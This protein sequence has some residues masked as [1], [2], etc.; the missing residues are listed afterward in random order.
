MPTDTIPP[1]EEL[2]LAEYLVRRV[3]GRATGASEDECIQT[4]PRDRYF[5]GSLRPRPASDDSA[6]PPTE[7]LN[8][9]APVAFGAEFRLE[10]QASQI[11]AHIHLDWT[12]YYRVFPALS[13]QRTHQRY[14]Q[15]PIPEPDDTEAT[16]DAVPTDDDDSVSDEATGDAQGDDEVESS[17]PA[18]IAPS[19]S[20]TRASRRRAP[21]DSLFVKFRKLRCRAAGTVFLNRP[22]DQSVAWEIDTSNLL[23]AISLEFQRVRTTILN[24]PDHLR[25]SANASS[26]LRVPANAL[27]SETS[28]SDFR[29]SLSSDVQPA[30]AWALG[31]EARFRQQRQPEIAFFFEAT[32][33]SD[34]EAKSWDREGFFFDVAATF[35]FEHAMVLPFELE[36]AASSFRYDRYLW[37]RG[38]NCAIE[39]SDPRDG[40]LSFT[41]L[42]APV[43]RQPRF[44]P[45]IEP[46]AD[47]KSLGDDP[48]PVLARILVAMGEYQEV[49]RTQREKYTAEDSTWESKYGSEYDSDWRSFTEETERFRRGFELIRTDPDIQLAFKL[50]NQSF[51]LA[52]TKS[53]WRL[54]QIVFLVA[55]LP[56]ISALRSGVDADS[57]DRTA[58]DIVYYPTGGGKT[59]AYLAVI[60]FH[61]FFDRLRGKTAG[62][63]AW[64][65]FPLRLLTL[66]QTQ[67]VADMI[68]QAE[69]VRRAQTDKRLSGTEIDG[70]AVGYFVGLESTP[71][72]IA[73]PANSIADATWS[74]AND[75]RARQKWKKIYRCPACPGS[76]VTVEFDSALAKLLHRCTSPQC[77]F[78]N[79]ILPV[80]IVD[81][82]IYRY[83]PSVVVGT[84][85]KLAA[86]GNQRKLSLVLGAVSGRCII[87]GYYNGKCCQ[88][89]CTNRTNLR[90]GAPVGV[91]AP[92]LIIQDE[93]HLLKEGLGT[94]DGHYETFLFAL[95]EA[96]GASQ[97]KIIASSATIEN[98]RRQTEHLYGRQARIFPSAGPTL[99]GSFYARTLAHPQRLFVGVL[100]H[101]KT[102]F[103]AVLELIQYYHEEIESAGRSTTKPYGGSLALGDPLWKKLID[104]YS[105]SL[106]YFSATRELNSIRTD[107]DAATNTELEQRGFSPL[108]IAELSGSTTTDDVTRILDSLEKSTSSV[109]PP[110]A[111]LATSMVS[112]G[113]DIERLNCMIFYGMPRQNAEYIQASSRVGRNHVG[114]VF[115]C[116]KPTRE[117]D[118]SHFAYFGKYHEFLDR[119]IEPVAINRWSK[120]SLRRTI[121]GL[122]MANLLQ[123]I[124]NN[125]GND[126][127]NRYYMVDFIKKQIS[128]GT[129]TAMDFVPLLEKAYLVREN[130]GVGSQ[131]FRDEI[132]VRVR[133]FLDQILGSG[134]QTSFVSEALI[135]TPMR[136]LRDV[137]EQ[138][139]I[140]LDSNGAA[141]A[142]RATR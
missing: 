8:K 98:F 77:K 126:N 25:I 18:N 55:Q 95:L 2:G 1:E 79:G 136:S 114:V 34:V 138:I 36:L 44:A 56:G 101:N 50:T 140:E 4:F 22:S 31:A 117:R 139:V 16:A 62:V 52:G 133:Q 46:V 128:Q 100:P 141:W 115:A 21:T 93:L 32:N 130:D 10:P 3:C 70:F 97:P 14:G 121:P 23:A 51:A 91:S 13:E 84:L 109:A 41:T 132:P 142:A 58:V 27:E 19:P 48:L 40:D 5:I 80:Y 89:D 11:E 74:T 81:N 57:N 78:P 87:H 75:P 61:C 110:N 29:S 72:E 59:E 43:F 86:L 88:R 37:G 71:N 63:T 65:R 104:Q 137:D 45:S 49:W 73:Q 9:L 42:N 113:V 134:A 20:Q 47:F 66:Q 119:L 38:F 94:F 96:F 116:M 35:R 39:K 122:F 33:D 120:F 108:R 106:T 103:R 124:A 90:Q 17:P 12:C 30:W 54:F 68:G 7:L 131:S 99:G 64:T 53:S 135:P 60:I 6:A 123:N 82:E 118:H 111:L 129:I 28:F 85:D 76:T 125:S 102:I 105:T 127:P 83:L 69:L 15:Q 67:R 112:H 107:L 24:D 92:T 26:R